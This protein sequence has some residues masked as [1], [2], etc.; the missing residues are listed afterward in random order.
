M[1]PARVRVALW[2]WALPRLIGTSLL[3]FT[4]L[5]AVSYVM[6]RLADMPAGWLWAFFWA[7]ALLLVAWSIK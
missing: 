4:V 6:L 7:G 1:T 2:R 5:L 3:I